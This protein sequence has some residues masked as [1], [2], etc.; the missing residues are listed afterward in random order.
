MPWIAAPQMRS[1]GSYS[2]NV[3]I[4]SEAE[5]KGTERDPVMHL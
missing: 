2:L 5:P 4:Q 1:G 3:Y